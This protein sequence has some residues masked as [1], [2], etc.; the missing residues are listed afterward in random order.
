MSTGALFNGMCYP[1]QS[2][3]A[4]A[5]YSTAAPATLPGSTSYT[6]FYRLIAGQWNYTQ[7][8]YNSSGVATNGW[9]VVVNSPTFP[10][11]DTLQNLN[12]GLTLGWLIASV[13][14]GVWAFKA[15]RKGTE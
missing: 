4:D 15:M 8:T 13:W 11:C 7:T 5:F 6:G 9:N 14:A 2:A 12:D 3:A 1:S 10:T